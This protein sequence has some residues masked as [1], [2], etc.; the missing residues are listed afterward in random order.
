MTESAIHGFEPVK[1]SSQIRKMDAET[2]SFFL[3]L[4]Q[5][6]SLPTAANRMAMSL[7]SANRLLAKLRDA[8]QDPLFVR[9]GQQMK[10]TPAAT[11][12]Y[13]RVQQI[14]R[15]IEALALD[16]TIDAK[17]I[18]QI[19]R[20]ATYDNAFCLGIAAVLPTLAT[21]LPH[22]QFRAYQAD[23]AMFDEL[24]ADHLDMVF[25]ARQG[26]QPD[27]RSIP[28][29]TTPYVCVTRRGHPLETLCRQTGHLEKDDLFAYKMVLIN[30]QPNR[31]REP[32]SPAN[33]WFNP[34]HASDVAVVV[35]FFL[36]ATTCL[37]E[38]DYYTIVPEATARLTLDSSRY[39][40]LPLTDKAPTLTIRLGWHERTHADPSAQLI[41]AILL[42]AVQEKMATLLKT[43]P[44]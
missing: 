30:A 8:W 10:P 41:R 5:T 42:E 27:I 16:D 7:S 18:K 32:N 31:N 11:R 34:P 28:L 35:P 36:A 9:S 29:C 39:A 25:F 23:E 44:S 4:Y 15:E 19:V 26:I 14:V 20:I 22:V 40:I 12:R 43:Q 3:T 33:G 6:E 37:V 1:V 21:K 13:D 17:K 2:L 38:T 24:R